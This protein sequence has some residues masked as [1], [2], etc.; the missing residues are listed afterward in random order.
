MLKLIKH[1]SLA[2]NRY[3]PGRLHCFYLVDLPAMIRWPV[4]A[5]I[6]LGHPSTRSKVVLCP[7]SDP[8]LPSALTTP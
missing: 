2:L 3:Y 6:A 4:Q 1:V 8:R 5:I 7:S